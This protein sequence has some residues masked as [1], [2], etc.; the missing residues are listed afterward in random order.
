MPQ[1]RTGTTWSRTPHERA[2]EP[3]KEYEDT[4]QK[5]PKKDERQKSQNKRHKKHTERENTKKW[6]TQPSKEGKEKKTTAQAI[7]A[8]PQSY[9]EAQSS[10]REGVTGEYLRTMRN[11]EE[12]KEGADFGTKAPRR[13]QGAYQDSTKPWCQTCTKH[14]AMLCTGKNCTEAKCYKCLGLSTPSFIDYYVCKNCTRNKV[15]RES[16]QHTAPGGKE[17]LEIYADN[18]ADCTLFLKDMAKARK[19]SSGHAGVI[20]RMRIWALSELGLYAPPFTSD[21]MMMWIMGKM[22]WARLSTIESDVTVIRLWQAEASRLGVADHE[23]GSPWNQEDERKITFALAISKRWGYHPKQDN[24]K[25]ALSLEKWTLYLEETKKARSWIHKMYRLTAMLLLVSFVRRGALAL[26][27][28]KRKN[29]ASSEADPKQSGI[30]IDPPSALH[31]GASAALVIRLNANFEKNQSQTVTTARYFSDEN[32][33]GCP[34][35]TM[36]V[37][38]LESLD[39][40]SGPLIRATKASH[41]PVTSNYWSKFL[42]HFAETTGIARETLGTQSFRR[43]YAQI[44][45]EVGGLTPDQL[46]TVGFWWGSSSNVYAGGHRNLRINLQRKQE[47]RRKLE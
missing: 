41:T 12:V 8:A 22:V 34:I 35:A 28:Y 6:D 2:R 9:K 10:R 47:N 30:A 21:M 18:V 11:Q 24:S 1:A 27:M 20:A 38:Q 31:T 19:T 37:E 26:A 7:K 45:T 33:L 15:L 39:M 5:A 40:P 16:G 13:A 3:K 32:C 17:K 42:L 14:R 44:L 25:E 43:G 46:Q 29:E 4:P 36:V 23:K